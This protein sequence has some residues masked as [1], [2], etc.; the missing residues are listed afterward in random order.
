VS[1][2]GKSMNST[3]QLLKFSGPTS[4]ALQNLERGQIFCQHYAAYN[5]PFE[6]W[7]RISSG[8]P[9]PDEEPQRYLAALR[10][11]GFDYRTVAEANSDPVSQESVDEY[12]EECQLYAPPFEAMR[13]EMRISCFSSE[14]DNLLMWSHYGDGLRGFCVAFDEGMI[15]Q[16][17]TTGYILDVAY[18]DAPPQVDS[19]VYGVAWDQD[20]YS[21]VAIE[22][23]E[24][25]IKY[26]GKVELQGDIAMFEKSGAEA[27]RT[28]QNIW[29]HVFA[30]KPVEWKYEQERRLLVQTDRTDA[31]P[32][33]R[34]FD[35][36]AIREVI[37]G[38]RMPEEY[39]VRLL[40]AVRQHY[41]D[42]VIRTAY[43][44]QTAYSLTI[45]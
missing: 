13:Q 8:I 32:I 6:F 34:S 17:D 2:V 45:E 26:Q 7:T 30:T 39:R 12:F 20:W 43:R 27:L 9:H 24:A 31:E 42:A 1:E 25:A 36:G 16:G 44:A 4:Y 21:H 28:M 15:T 23:T 11:W 14:A 18:R 33:F 10:A 37:L 29:Q 41:P 3:C 19:F 40:A 5:D 35:R 22:E 38:E